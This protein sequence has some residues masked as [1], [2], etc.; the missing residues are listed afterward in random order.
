M[1]HTGK[2]TRENL[3]SSR[4]PAGCRVSQRVTDMLFPFHLCL[5]FRTKTFYRPSN[6]SG[7]AN[8][9]WKVWDTNLKQQYKDEKKNAVKT[10]PSP[11]RCPTYCFVMENSRFSS[12]LS[13]FSKKKKN[14]VSYL[15]HFWHRQGKANQL[16]W[17]LQREPWQLFITV[18]NS[19]DWLWI[20]IR[21][22][23]ETGQPW[24]GSGP[25]RGQRAND[26]ISEKSAEVLQQVMK[27]RHEWSFGGWTGGR[28]R[29][30]SI[31]VGGLGRFGIQPQHLLTRGGWERLT[32][33]LL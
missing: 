17:I 8:F 27:W 16:W 22:P 3:R 9:G 4:W 24:D 31:H 15:I 30:A 25:E 18:E 20:S 23:S 19:S 29:Q 21:S 5:K 33:S 32:S 13:P 26:S 1:A 2:W 10:D 12:V 7:L 14:K 28:T 6:G 11:L